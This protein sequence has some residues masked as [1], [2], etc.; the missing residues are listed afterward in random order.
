SWMWMGADEV[1]AIGY[2]SSEANRPVCVTGAPNKAVAAL[3]KIIPD[4]WALAMMARQ[5]NRFRK[6]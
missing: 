1:A 6:A 3:A 4:D 5:S 2:E